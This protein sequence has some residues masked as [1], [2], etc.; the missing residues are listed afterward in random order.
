MREAKVTHGDM[1]ATNLMWVNER[2]FFIDLD[3][4]KKHVSQQSWQH[5]HK[6]DVKRF[7][8]NWR[9]QPDLLSLFDDLQ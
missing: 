1:K 5:A 3:G 9:D 2:L 7:L 4:A 8:K 6:K